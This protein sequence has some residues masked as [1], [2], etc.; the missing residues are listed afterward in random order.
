MPPPPKYWFLAGALF[1]VSAAC[2]DVDP[3][4]GSTFPD[5]VVPADNPLSDEAI[6]LGRHLFY[7]ARLSGNQSVS[8]ASC[9]QPALA[10]ADDQA[11]SIGATGERGSHN[12][13][14]LANVAYASPLTWAHG[15]LRVIEDQLLGPMFGTAPIEMGMAGNE[16]AIASRLR[17][18]P[19]YAELFADAFGAAA[20]DGSAVLDD[21]RFALASFSRSLVSG[22]SSFDFFLAGER[23]AISESARRGSELFYSSRLGCGNCHAG[24]ALSEASRS[25]NTNATPTSPFHNIGLYNTDGEGSYPN[26]APGLISDSGIARDAGRFRVPSLRNVAVTAP[27][28]HDGSVATLAE[29]VDIYE[30]GGRLVETGPHAGDGR[31]NPLRSAEL[32]DFELETTEKS[33]LLAFLEALTDEQFL[34]DSSHANPWP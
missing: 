9:H 25:V 17:A 22:S 8:C 20:I 7:D 26:V 27:Y 32:P 14:S 28:M 30:R 21:A 2:G 31:D 18:E 4:A 11:L 16:D 10:F 33:D 15:N 12:A 23:E 13:P 5:P 19:L 34:T 24:F 1:A 6:E 29:V 3:D